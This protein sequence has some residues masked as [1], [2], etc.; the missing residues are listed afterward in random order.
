[1]MSGRSFVIILL[2]TTLMLI[3]LNNSDVRSQVIHKETLSGCHQY[4]AFLN[5]SVVLGTNV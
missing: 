4:C 5:D 3:L 2:S 1:M